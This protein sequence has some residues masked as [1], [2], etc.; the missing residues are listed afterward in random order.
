MIACLLL[1]IMDYLGTYTVCT[2]GLQLLSA[3]PQSEAN[4]CF[5]GGHN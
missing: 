1:I 4:F 5:I 3:Q 2:A